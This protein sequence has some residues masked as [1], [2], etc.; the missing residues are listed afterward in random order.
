MPMSLAGENQL[1]GD[2]KPLAAYASN[3]PKD[4]LNLNVNVRIDIGGDKFIFNGSFW[5][6][7]EYHS[8]RPKTS[9]ARLRHDEQGAGQKAQRKWRRFRNRLDIK[10]S[11]GN[12]HI[13]EDGDAIGWS[14]CCAVRIFHTSLGPVPY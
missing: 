1:L 10:H 11:G 3:L 8:T 9:F 12:S 6:R 4:F 2:Q 14:D 7:N 13:R 5:H